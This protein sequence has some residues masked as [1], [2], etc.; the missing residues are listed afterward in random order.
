MKS[1]FLALALVLV[2]QAAPAADL[3]I[4]CGDIQTYYVEM[5]LSKEFRSD[6]NEIATQTFESGKEHQYGGRNCGVG[7]YLGKPDYDVLVMMDSAQPLFRD[8]M[9]PMG[10]VGARFKLSLKDEKALKKGIVLNGKRNNLTSLD[11]SVTGS[12]DL[13]RTLSWSNLTVIIRQ[14]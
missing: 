10:V 4:V 14:K 3:T 1:I 7:G 12:I 9:G 5:D 8:T 13:A 11:Q 2:S 6:Y